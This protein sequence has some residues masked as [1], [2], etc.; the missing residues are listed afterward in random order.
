MATTFTVEDSLV[1]DR[2]II[3]VGTI[4]NIQDSPERVAKALAILGRKC[5]DF[6]DNKDHALF[7]KSYRIEIVPVD[8]PRWEYQ[9]HIPAK[10]W[11]YMLYYKIA[12]NNEEK[13]IVLV[14]ARD[15]VNSV[16]TSYK[17][18]FPET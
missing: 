2:P 5:L 18:S 10:A 3:K 14:T 15:Y 17:P 12:Q 11:F 9:L 7:K 8:H 4:E 16:R 1:W 13:R 6:V